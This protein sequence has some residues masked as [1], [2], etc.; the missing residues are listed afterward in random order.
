[1]G[2]S[3]CWRSLLVA[4]HKLNFR[5]ALLR[6]G[7]VL[8][9]LELRVVPSIALS[10]LVPLVLLIVEWPLALVAELI[11]FINAL[12]V[13]LYFTF[14][15]PAVVLVRTL[16]VL[17]L[18]ELFLFHLVALM[19][20]VVNQLYLYFLLVHFI[21]VLLFW[22]H[23]LLALVVKMFVANQVSLSLVCTTT[24]LRFVGCA[25]WLVSLFVKTFVV[26]I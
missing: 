8:L 22:I 17:F 13:T 18:L 19:Y 12:L 4:Y 3:L 10:R 1:M 11:P 23:L 26:A 7:F 20:L 14:V 2:D 21:L 15:A 16:L 6:V 24:A 25:R 5:C 9:A